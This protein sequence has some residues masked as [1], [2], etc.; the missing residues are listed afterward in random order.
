AMELMDGNWSF[1]QLIRQIMTSRVYQLGSALG[2]DAEAALQADPDNNLLWRMNQRRLEAE[3]IRDSMLLASGQ[4]DL[5]PGR[6]SVIESIG[7]GSVGQNIRVDRFLGESRKR[8]V[9]LPI[10]R[11]AVPE[12]LQVFDFPDP[13]IIYGQ[14]EVTTV[15]TQSLFMMNNGFVIE[16]SRQFAERILSEVPEDNA[17]RVE[18]AYR[19]ALAR[20]AKPA[21]V[22]AATE[23]I[24][25][26]EQSM[27]SKQQAWSS[28][29]QTLFACSEFRY[30]D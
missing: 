8:S 30:V 23:F 29:C 22:A 11:G 28:F 21:E 13:S 3:A 27:E 2:P 10:V 14:R 25:L 1:K 6:G 15:P 16:Q 18:L 26:A 4:L 20:E 5:S 17:Q 7:D 12:L 19:L 24:R 9:Y